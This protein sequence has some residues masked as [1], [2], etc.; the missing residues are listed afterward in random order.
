M[1]Y[2]YV[3][4]MIKDIEPEKGVKNGSKKYDWGND[5]DC[6]TIGIYFSKKK[7]ITRVE[8]NAMDIRDNDNEYA[9][10]E[11]TAEGFWLIPKAEYWFKWNY[12]EERYCSI[13]KPDAISGIIN[14]G[15]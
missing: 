7:A 2:V 15:C 11:K 3:V 6:H 8:E 4:T 9:V 12:D 10:I 14:F 5:F 13:K 1:K